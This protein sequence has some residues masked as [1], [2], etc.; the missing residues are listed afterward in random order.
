[1]LGAVYTS[2]LV[3]PEG[4]AAGDRAAAGTLGGAVDVAQGLPGG[5]AAAVADSARAAFSSG[6]DAAAGIGVAVMV[7][8]AVL[9]ATVWREPRAP[10]ENPRS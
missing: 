9:V 3:L 10:A 2:R 8:A 4:L 1:M 7:A 5:A 6:M